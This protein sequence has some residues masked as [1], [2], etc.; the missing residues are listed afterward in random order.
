[1]TRVT[2]AARLRAFV[3]ALAAA[4]AFACGKKPVP[5]PA[6][7]P[8]ENPANAT[9]VGRAACGSCHLMQVG[10]WRT[11]NH[12]M[13]M[14]EPTSE[15]VSGDFANAS[16]T[17]HGVTSTFTKK[18]GKFLVRTD[19]ADGARHDY[20]V[21]WTFGVYPLQQYLIRFP[22]GRVQAL[23]VVWDARPKAEGGRRWFHL[24][25]DE[26]VAATDVLHWTGP[27]QNWNFMCADC[28][29]TNVKKGWDTATD[30]YTTTFSEIDVSCEACHGPGSAHVAWA[31]AV[32]DRHADAKSEKNGVLVGRKDRDGGQ[33]VIDPGKPVARRTVSRTNRSE[34]ETCAR[35]HARRSVVSDGYAPGSPLMDFYRPQLLDETLYFPDGQIK[36]EVYEYASFLQSRMYSSGVTC[37]DCHDAHTMKLRAPGDAICGRCHAPEAYT[38]PKHHFHKGLSGGAS[39]LGCHMPTRNYMVV[40]ARHDHSIRI[41]RP[42]LSARL[43][44]PNACASCHAKKGLAWQA[45]AFAKWWP[46]RSGTP[47]PGEAIFAGREGLRGARTALAALVRDREASPPMRATAATLLGAYPGPEAGPAL[48]LALLDASP[49]VRMG[50]AAALRGAPPDVRLAKLLRLLEDPVRTVRIDAARSLATIPEASLA[51]AQASAIRRG[52]AEWRAA[53]L[54]DADRAEAHLNVGAL[55]AE[56]GDTATAQAEYRKA[57]ALTPGLPASYVNLADLYRQLGRDGDADETLK[58]GLAIT[59]D[60]AD[61]H[62]ALGLLRVRQKRLPEAVEELRKA[63]QLRPGAARYAFVYGVALEAAGR[64]AESEAVLKK[65]LARH[66]GDPE[67]LSALLSSSL[68]RND[69]TAAFGWAKRLSEAVPD[70]TAVSALVAK[71]SG[72]P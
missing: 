24:Y 59:P 6:A 20:E 71:L 44:T 13:A 40:H 16:F 12:A 26:N 18:G 35:C 30:T 1:M 14:A 5:G 70:D 54:V 8:W 56:T 2:I 52:V 67:I 19:G 31:E 42:D 55:A 60:A 7:V 25:P 36:E 45:A 3:A 65:A 48:D 58:R 63:A 21:A 38:T 22:K 49:L 53:Q 17:Y 23:N 69:A 39:C 68:K 11:S 50:G 64:A 41:P 32:R 57:I 15:T 51:Q 72:A 43:G 37:T 62:H 61:L 47:H 4:L 66:T 28:H 27:Y 29:S 34:V 10:T 46:K 33:W 9:Y